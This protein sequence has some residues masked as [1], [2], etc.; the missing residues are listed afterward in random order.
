M[1]PKG[2]TESHK[3]YEYNWQEWKHGFARR[4][5]MVCKDSGFFK[6]TQELDKAKPGQ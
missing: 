3:H 1:N 2:K 4:D 5:N 6:I